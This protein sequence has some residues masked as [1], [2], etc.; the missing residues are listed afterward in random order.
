MRTPHTTT[1]AIREAARRIV[2][3]CLSCGAP[4]YGDI[5][6]AACRKRVGR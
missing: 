3:G 1:E 4:V 6:C 2:N 5:F